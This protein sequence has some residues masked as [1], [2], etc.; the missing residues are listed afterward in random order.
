M[1][2][3]MRLLTSLVLAA[4]PLAAQQPGKPD[5]MRH[6]IMG[7]GHM[8]GMMM[9]G[10]MMEHVGPAM[11]KMMLYTPQHLLARRDALGLTPDQ[12]TRLS[13]LRD[14]T[15]TA[16]DAAM[17]EARS[18]MAAIEQAAND[19]KPDTAVLKAHFQAAHD[20]VGKAHWALLASAAQ[21]RA[22][23]TDAQRAKVQVWADSMQ[24]WRQQHRQMMPPDR[25]H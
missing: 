21:A 18:H 16:H 5:S 12:V 17:N 19:A 6:H 24:A 10:S 8:S 25:P 14:G 2:K 3:G 20:A 9:Q 4:A 11:M 22:V 1:M 7:P 15:K 23:L 13:A